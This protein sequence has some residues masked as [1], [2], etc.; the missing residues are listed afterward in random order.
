M[1]LA[2]ANDAV[3]EAASK[4]AL[5]AMFLRDNLLVASASSASREA[6]LEA[7]VKVA[8][9][10]N[11]MVRAMTDLLDAAPNSAQA[12]NE[13]DAKLRDFIETRLGAEHE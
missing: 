9:D 11:R 1:S 4:A 2:H 13:Y 6:R 3:G 8:T 12:G 7:M 5:W 10:W